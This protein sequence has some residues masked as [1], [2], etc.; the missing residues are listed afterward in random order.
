MKKILGFQLYSC[1]GN[2]MTNSAVRAYYLFTIKPRLWF[3][4][5]EQEN[6]QSDVSPEK[7]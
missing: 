5:T 1:E 2:Y 7:E 6:K 3:P 4:A